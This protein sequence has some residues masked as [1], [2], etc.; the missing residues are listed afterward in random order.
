MCCCCA[1]SGTT[2][3]GVTFHIWRHPIRGHRYAMA[4]NSAT[5]WVFTITTVKASTAVTAHV[6]FTVSI[7]A[8]A[9]G[10][11][12]ANEAS[13]TYTIKYVVGLGVSEL[14]ACCT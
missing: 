8:A 1:C 13:G 3:A 11:N 5:E 9:A 7:G 6:G 2:S 14:R 10:V 12:P 4:S